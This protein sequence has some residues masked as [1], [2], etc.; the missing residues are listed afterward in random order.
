MA[1]TYYLG[2]R[3]GAVLRFPP[4]VTSVIWP[5][6]SLLTA[7]L[8]LTPPTRWW[9]CLAAAFPAHW[10]ALAQA[11][12]APA[13]V[14]TLFGTNCLEAV[15]AAGLMRAWSD[16]PNRFD[17]LQRALA[18]VG[19]AVVLG[20]LVS[21]FPDAAAVNYFQ[22]D[23]YG[24]VCIRRLLSNSLSQLTLVPSAVLLVRQ[25]R[26]WLRASTRRK[27]LEATLLA[28]ALVSAGLDGL[29]R[30]PARA[31][32]PAGGA[33]HG[34]AVPDAAPHRLG[35]PLR[36]LRREP[37]AAGHGAARDRH[38]AVGPLAPHR[39]AGRAAGAWRCRCS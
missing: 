21:T 15:L 38:R 14:V 8:L 11:G 1:A 31:S 33:L 13:F 30:L 35:G 26:Q 36:A 27:R 12:F 9:L 7:A 32:V 20:P 24:L 23:P 18:F 28:V 29:Q 3:L 4:A 37:L 39:P 17:T 2:A 22:G 25:G 34:A 16:D 19:G 6:N 10:L 5:P